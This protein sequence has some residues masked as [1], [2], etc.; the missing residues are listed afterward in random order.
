MDTAPFFADV[1]EGPGDGAAWWIRADDNVRL[2]VGLWNRAAPRGTVL[3]WPGRTE[4]IE[5]Y[6]RAAT[7]FAAGGYAT[8]AIDWRGQGL[9]DRLLGDAM[10]GHVHQFIDYQHDVAAMM[11]AAE[12]LDLPRPW[13]LLAHSMG[14]CIGLRAVMQGLDV[15]SVAFS[16]PMWGIR[17]A[18]ALRP[19]AWSLSWGSRQVGL[20]HRYA[21]GT[22]PEHYVLSEPFATNKLT[23][24]A[25][26]WAYMEQQIRAHPEL[27]LGGPSLHWLF[28]AL[29]ETRGLA[30][31]P[32]PALPCLTIL[33][34]DEEIVDVPRVHDR[35]ARW[36]GGR[37]ELV[38]GGRHETLMDTEDTQA[39]LFGLL[40]DFYGSAA[41]N[42]D[43]ECRIADLF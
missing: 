29:R 9:A 5:K 37:L 12:R 7:R 20:S 8:F 27:G 31:R 22:A 33:G 18:D 14:G 24:D 21:P 40:C 11:R 1:A 19:V 25:G 35:M 34:S 32:S 15:A 39:H 10:S 36:P 2:R 42:P 28:E 41:A 6:G 17:M 13:H 43:S 4:Y 16:G 30:R 38:P 3:L 23:N 26:M